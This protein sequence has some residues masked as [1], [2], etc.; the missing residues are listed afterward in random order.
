MGSVIKS[1]QE[2]TIR[3]IIR[4]YY[5][6]W[7]IF[8]FAGGF[9][10]G[11]YPIFLHSRGLN[12]FQIN[13]VLAMYFIVLFFT[14][15]PTGAFADALGRRRSF[16]AGTALRVT[17]FMVYFFAH[18]Y[19]VFLIAESIDG[20][21]TTFCN[22]AIDA[23]GVD[24]LDEAGYDGLKDRLF[25]RISQL[26]SAAFMASALIGTYVADFNIAWPWLL[27]A[28]GYLIAGVAGAVLMRDEKP[29]ATEIKLA[30]M[31][32]HVVQQVREGIQLGL[33]TEV[34]LWLSLAGSISFA[35]WAPYWIE[36]P[37]MFNERFNVGIWIIGWIYCGLTL[38]RMIGA[39]VMIRIGGD[40]Y[41]RAGRV[42]MLIIVA[43]A[44]L[45]VAGVFGHRPFLA[46]G[47]LF[48]MNLATGAMQPLLQSWFNEQIESSQRA[49]LLSFASTFQTMGGSIGLLAGGAIADASGIPFEW[50]I[51][52]LISLVAAPI[53]WSLRSRSIMPMGA[54]STID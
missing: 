8:S 18:H 49:T 29:R 31:P 19:F 25:S 24:A 26:S 23:W 6:V 47:M 30:G 12:Q 15:V 2:L 21:G 43:S 53:Y 14:D 38:A 11:V 45:F 37:L 34:V 20:I 17:A 9:L 51:A 7:W 27:G 52:G 48:V 40:E 41:E 35:A 36:W 13:S 22:G 4:R 33:K 44:M 42:S 54:A 32:L 46:L 5:A 16:M 1:P 10:F 3:G 28:A 50:Q 39:E